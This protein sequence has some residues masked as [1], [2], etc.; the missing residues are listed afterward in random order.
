MHDAGWLLANV[1][2]VACRGQFRVLC[3]SLAGTREEAAR[4]YYGIDLTLA[5]GRDLI[6]RRRTVEVKLN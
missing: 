2:T 5:C 6:I 3:R 4:N 1:H